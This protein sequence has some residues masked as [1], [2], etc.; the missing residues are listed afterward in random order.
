MSP[1]QNR[2]KSLA[3]PDY[4]IMLLYMA[5]QQAQVRSRFRSRSTEKVSEEGSHLR[6][7][8]VKGSQMCD[9]AVLDDGN[10]VCR[11]QEMHMMSHQDPGSRSQQPANAVEPQ[12]LPHMCVDG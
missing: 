4:S 3:A 7:E 6:L 11:L 9:P 2:D 10:Q 5:R 12:V 8:H 1:P